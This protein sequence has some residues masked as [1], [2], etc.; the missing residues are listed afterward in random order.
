MIAQD[1][2]HLDLEDIHLRMLK[3]QQTFKSCKVAIGE[4]TTAKATNMED[5]PSYIRWSYKSQTWTTLCIFNV[6]RTAVWWPYDGLGKHSVFRSFFFHPMGRETT[7]YVLSH[8]LPKCN[9]HQIFPALFPTDIFLA[10]S[11]LRHLKIIVDQMVC[12]KKEKAFYLFQYDFQAR[13]LQDMSG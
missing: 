12:T 10:I 6:S 11:I 1:S 4:E 9:Q 8:A 13:S 5:F 2:I 3:Q 7:A